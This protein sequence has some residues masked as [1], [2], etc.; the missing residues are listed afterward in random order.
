MD[1]LIEKTR[2]SSRNNKYQ[3]GDSF[4]TDEKKE[5]KTS[6]EW[7][8]F[9]IQEQLKSLMYVNCPLRGYPKK[10]NFID[11][12]NFKNCVRFN[13]NTKSKFFV[14]IT[15]TKN[16]MIHPECFGA[17]NIFSHPFI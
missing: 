5:K 10:D 15:T 9:V 11:K 6:L 16:C 17:N 4:R 1:I 12:L 13:R 7:D 8:D 2:S 3:R 14:G